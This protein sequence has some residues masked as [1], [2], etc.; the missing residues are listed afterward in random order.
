MARQRHLRVY[1]GP[2]DSRTVALNEAKKVSKGV[3]MSLAELA[4]ALIQASEGGRAWVDDFADE[5]IT[6]S[7]D[8]YEVIHAYQHY[9]SRDVA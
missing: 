7:S 3:E 2:E 6:V 9:R 4:N 5:P 8:L 1:Y